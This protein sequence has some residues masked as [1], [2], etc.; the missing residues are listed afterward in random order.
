MARERSLPSGSWQD[1]NPQ[2]NKQ[3]KIN[4]N[5]S[6]LTKERKRDHC[7]QVVGKEEQTNNQSNK[8]TNKQTNMQLSDD[9]R[10]VDA[11]ELQVAILILSI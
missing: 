9:R 11:F 10:T 7:P 6:V 3:T 1:K 8:Q 2:I 4:K 5:K